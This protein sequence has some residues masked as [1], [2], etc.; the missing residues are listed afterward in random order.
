MR[1]G[2]FGLGFSVGVPTGGDAA[3]LPRLVEVMTPVV[4]WE[5]GRLRETLRGDERRRG[6]FSEDA[7]GVPTCDEVVDDEV[8][9]V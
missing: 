2:I 7:S 8:D 1:L 4:V 6:E 5:R 3:E 9:I